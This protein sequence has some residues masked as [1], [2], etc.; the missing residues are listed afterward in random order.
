MRFRFVAD[1]PI[2]SST[3][4]RL[5]FDKVVRDVRAAL[6]ETPFVYGLLGPWGSGKTSIQK[7]LQDAYAAELRGPTPER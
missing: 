4:D 3:R 7:L 2:A 6:T 1:E 5:G